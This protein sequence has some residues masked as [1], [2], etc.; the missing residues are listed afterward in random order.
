MLAANTEAVF[1]TFRPFS[2]RIG[3]RPE[4]KGE[5]DAAKRPSKPPPR[6]RVGRRSCPA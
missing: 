6:N 5:V 2:V 1:G 3:P 4:A